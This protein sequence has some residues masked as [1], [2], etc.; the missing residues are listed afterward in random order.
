M[1]ELEVLQDSLREFIQRERGNQKQVP[2]IY[3]TQAIGSKSNS[4]AHLLPQYQETPA[5]QVTDPSD[6]NFG[7][8]YYAA[9]ISLID[10]EVIR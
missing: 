3:G 7:Q 10:S 1:R 8:W 9:D 5:L 6:P 4:F 2:F